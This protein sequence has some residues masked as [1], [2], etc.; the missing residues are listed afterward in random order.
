MASVVIPVQMET[1]LGDVFGAVL[2]YS[3]LH[4]T[5]QFE[6]L[7]ITLGSHFSNLLC[8]LFYGLQML[9]RMAY[10]LTGLVHHVL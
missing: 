6:N 9:Q 1:H 10:R 4:R 7:Q 2:Y 3:C 5:Q 8:L